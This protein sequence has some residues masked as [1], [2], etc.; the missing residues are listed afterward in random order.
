MCKCQGLIIAISGG[1]AP[2][3]YI[4][5]VRGEKF[6]YGAHMLPNICMHLI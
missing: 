4:L 2:D 1:T 3:L 6:Q 5:N